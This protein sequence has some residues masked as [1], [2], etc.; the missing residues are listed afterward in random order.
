MERQSMCPLFMGCV[1]IAEQTVSLG[2]IY[3]V[4][5]AGLK[6]LV[7]LYVHLFASERSFLFFLLK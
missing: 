7:L 5:N 4:N 3:I 1:G 6:D 2:I